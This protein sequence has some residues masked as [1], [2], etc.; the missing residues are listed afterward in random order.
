MFIFVVDCGVVSAN[1]MLCRQGSSFMVCP[2]NYYNYYSTV[3]TVVGMVLGWY[4]VTMDN[5]QGIWMTRAA[6]NWFI[7]W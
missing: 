6:F 4:D 3:A 7:R 5:G 1:H 2:Q